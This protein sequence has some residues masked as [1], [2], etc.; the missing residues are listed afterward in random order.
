MRRPLLPALLL[1]AFPRHALCYPTGLTEGEPGDLQ[2]PVADLELL[3]ATRPQ[4]NLHFLAHS[5]SPRAAGR[6]EARH[7]AREGA[8]S[9]Q[10]DGIDGF[11]MFS[12]RRPHSN[13]HP[14]DRPPVLGRGSLVDWQKA[15]GML[16]RSSMGML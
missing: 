15:T 11:R 7:R 14:T 1:L 13:G 12:G 3:H 5:R 10:P 16:Q 6:Q 8:L 4:F 9:A 2:R